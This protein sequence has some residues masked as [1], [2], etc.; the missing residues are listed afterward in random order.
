MDFVTA[1]P[2]SPAGNDTVLVFVDRFSKMVHLVPCKLTS[3]A[4]D[5][6]RLFVQHVFRLHGL[7]QHIVSDRNPRFTA[8]FMREL[9]RLLG[10]HQGLSTAFHP[11]T[12]GQTEI[13]N[14]RMEDILRHFVGPSQSGWDSLLPCVE[15][16][17]NSSW[18]ESIQETPFVLNYGRHPR[19]PFSVQFTAADL[20]SSVPAAQ[21][22]T[23][24]MQLATVRAKACLVAA[25][26]RQKAAADKGRR[27]VAF[28][29]GESVLLHSRN[30][31]LKGGARK[32]MPKWVGPFPVSA[33]V[34][35]V[36]YRLELPAH[37]RIHDVFHVSL[38]KPY[39]SDGTVQPPPP[40]ELVDG[41]PEWEVEA[42]LAQ[43]P[44]QGRRPA[45]YLVRWKGYAP[46]HDSWEPLSG[47][48][49]CAG[50][51]AAYHARM[52]P[53]PPSLAALSLT[54]ATGANATPLGADSQ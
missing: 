22:F 35:P 51:L 19:T 47:L 27:D 25:L 21:R 48:T 15:F 12:D 5:V 2:R 39:R 40:P 34:N 33:V 3:T 4:E 41:E 16:A 20:A 45:R 1:L 9:C 26:A 37:W 6:A 32:L 17:I 8:N 52:A 30:L 7:P 53:A 29:V 36:A 38:L 31:S 23:H 50:M 24:E 10:V 46:V 49:N 14:R 44:K 11:Q 18:H 42:I 13:V 43:V 28:S 54:P